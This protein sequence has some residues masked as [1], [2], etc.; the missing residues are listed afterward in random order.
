MP[1]LLE[2]V[3]LGLW[4][5]LCSLKLQRKFVHRG[6]FCCLG[7]QSRVSLDIHT[8]TTTFQDTKISMYILSCCHY[9]RTYGN[10]QHRQRLRQRHRQRHRHPHRY[11]GTRNTRSTET[12]ST[13]STKSTP[14]SPTMF[15]TA[16]L[17]VYLILGFNRVIFI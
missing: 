10:R 13:G 12:G 6:R 11:Q 2:R 17:I 8:T 15:I 5:R 9:V 16:V 3:G 1:V 14:E 7:L 4:L